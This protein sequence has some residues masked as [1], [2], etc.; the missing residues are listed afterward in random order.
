MRSAQLGKSHRHMDNAGPL[1]CVWALQMTG[2]GRQALMSTPCRA[3]ITKLDSRLAWQLGPAFALHAKWQA[4]LPF[5]Q[6]NLVV[7][8]MALQLAPEY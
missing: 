5:T 7:V 2:D 8:I 3:R 4:K 6:D 1:V